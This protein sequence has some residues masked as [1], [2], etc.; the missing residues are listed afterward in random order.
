M[1]NSSAGSTSGSKATVLL[2]FKDAELYRVNR[3]S[4]S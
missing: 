3:L 2:Q 1:L 4:R